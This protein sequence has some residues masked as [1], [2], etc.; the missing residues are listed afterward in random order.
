MTQGSKQFANSQSTF[1]WQFR[2]SSASMQNVHIKCPHG[3]AQKKN[4]SNTYA[5]NFVQFVSFRSHSVAEHSR[6]SSEVILGTSF[7]TFTWFL[8]SSSI[9]SKI[10]LL[11]GRRFVEFLLLCNVP[12]P[13][14]SA[15]LLNL[16]EALEKF[17]FV[18]KPSLN[19][20]PSNW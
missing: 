18:N 20:F 2:H 1:V 5:Q 10:S 14:F 13:F 4:C 6:G 15:S 7:S 12:L 8:S 17:L 19:W 3:F 9:C 11:H 16:S